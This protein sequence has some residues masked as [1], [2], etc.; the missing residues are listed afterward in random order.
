M[1]QGGDQIAEQ[2]I[3]QAGVVC[4]CPRQCQ[5]VHGERAA[6]AC[7]LLYLC[8]QQILGQK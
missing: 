8:G 4:F 7:N 5:R 3:L 6:F 2:L 1:E